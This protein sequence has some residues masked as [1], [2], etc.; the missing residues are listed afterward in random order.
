MAK[1]EFK[2]EVWGLFDL[3]KKQILIFQ[4]VLLI[5]FI[6]LTAFLFAYNFHQHAGNESF[7]FHATYAKY[8]SLAAT[9]LIVIETQFLWSMFTQ[10]QLDLINLQKT[11]IEQQKE[12]I[13]TQNNQLIEH[14]EK[15]LGHQEKIETQNKDIKD[16]IKYASKIQSALFPSEKNLKSI[17]NEY[18]LLYKP[19]DFVSGDFYWIDNY[20]GKIIVVAADCTGHGVPAA[21]VSALGI[22]IL[23]DILQRAVSD[24]EY[25]N[26]AIMLNRLRE[27]LVSSIAG[28]DYSKDTYDGMDVVICMIDKK[29]NKLEYASARQPIYLV[30][31]TA[32]KYVLDLLRPDIHSISMADD[33]EHVYKNNF[34]IINPNDLLYL[35]SDGYA[36]Q[37]GGKKQ[38]K[39][40]SSNLRE[41]LVAVADKPL[42]MQ[43]DIL[44]GT[45][46]EWQGEIDQ[47]DD[48]MVMGIK[49]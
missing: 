24:K 23:N 42:E 9:I 10:A 15:I 2:V 14:R 41:L 35:F 29:Q 7:N 26:P 37:F 25:L 30:K 22:S 18:F 43:K 45:L 5:L 4:L 39:F 33:N 34:A 8:F 11:E 40:L 36:D 13:L 19:R 17:L 31:K 21:L 12:E 28:T 49:I 47:I 48:I 1:E 27:R 16:S 46:A 3:T 32:E 44:S 20:N 6:V 38:K